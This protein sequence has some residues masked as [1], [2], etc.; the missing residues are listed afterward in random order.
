M[1]RHHGEKI[2]LLSY[3]FPPAGGV[4]VQRI[5]SLSKYLPGEGCQV[6]VLTA[7]NGAYPVSDPELLRQVPGAVKVY[8]AFTPEIPYDLRL[9]VWNL[10]GGWDVANGRARA[11]RALNKLG[12]LVRASAKRALVPDPQVVWYPFALRAASRLVLHDGFDTVVV[13]APPFSSFL[14]GNELKRR[15]PAV[16]LVSDFRDDWLGFYL[17]GVDQLVTHGKRLDAIAL[18]RET[19]EVCD[20]VVATTKATARAMHDRHPCVPVSKF[21]VVPNGFDPSLPLH[22]SQATERSHR[23]GKMVATY[24]GTVYRP[25]SPRHWLD[26][27]DSL[28]EAMRSRIE[29]RFVGRVIPEE[30]PI[31]AGR[32]SSV[33]K[34]GFMPQ[35]E[36]IRW[37]AETDYLLLVVDDELTIP[38][39]LFEYLATGKPI[40]ALTPPRGESG[41]LIA[42]AQ[43]GWVAHPCDAAA[44]AELAV[45][46]FG[47]F[48]SGEARVAPRW[49]AIRRFERPRLAARY[50]ELIR[51][52]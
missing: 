20:L 21:A 39:K 48:L 41:R 30:E 33:V 4:A 50:R 1:S 14:V 2:L 52:G 40:L 36:A 11:P 19:L 27:V 26:V 16:K 23:R 3:F 9:K 45:M 49:D 38:G 43:S 28:P 34:L 5:L 32:R 15:F 25:S 17:S 37:I 12:H 10:L 31:L 18:E 24:V 22:F 8:R 13:T 44:I 7:W 46:A 35:A 42:E 6:S 47:R 29:T 51:E